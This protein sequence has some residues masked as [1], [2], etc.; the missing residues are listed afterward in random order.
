MTVTRDPKNN[1][2]PCPTDEDRTCKVDCEFT[3]NP[4]NEDQCSNSAAG[5][6]RATVVVGGGCV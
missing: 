5:Q 6:V 3:W 2:I 4:W 1:G